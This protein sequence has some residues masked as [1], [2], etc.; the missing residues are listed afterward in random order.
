[1]ANLSQGPIDLSERALN[2]TAVRGANRGLF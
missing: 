2:S 1:M